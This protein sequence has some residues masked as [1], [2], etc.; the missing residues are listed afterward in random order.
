MKFNPVVWTGSSEESKS[1]RKKALE[2]PA[3]NP[4]HVNPAEHF[5]GDLVKLIA[6]PD[7]LES[8]QQIIDADPLLFSPVEVM[9]DA[10]A[11]HHDETVT[12]VGCLVHGMCYHQRGQ[13]LTFHNF[14]RH[15]DY[16][17]SALGVESGGM[18]VEQKQFR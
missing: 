2:N 8:C 6:T 18:L 9:N 17:F 16:L 13:L 12:E 5:G 7:F 4:L 15:R 1:P 3:V 10:A 11:M 14:V